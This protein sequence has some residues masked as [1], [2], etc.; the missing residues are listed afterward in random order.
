[1][2]ESEAEFDAAVRRVVYEQLVATG[3]APDAGTL[4][5]SLATSAQ[6]VR[7][8]L[9]RLAAARVLVLQP[10]TRALWMAMPLSAVPTGFR[11]RTSRGDRWANCA[12]DALGIPA[13]LHEP[14]RIETT[15]FDC[16]DELALEVGTE[17]VIVREAGEGPVIHFAV[18][19]RHWWDDIGFT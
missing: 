6:S 11:V 12:W 2:V 17:G 5:A 10:D 19:A 1:M 3:A 9:E 18:P 7:E 13:M 4:A 14:A 15:C 8:A 16:G